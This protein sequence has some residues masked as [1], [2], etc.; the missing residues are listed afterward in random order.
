[1]NLLVTFQAKKSKELTILILAWGT[2]AV[3]HKRYQ[4]N[5]PSIVEC[6]T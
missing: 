3:P 1:M 5:T 2:S 4:N 6:G